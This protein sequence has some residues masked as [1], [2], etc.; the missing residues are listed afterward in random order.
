LADVFREPAR[1][2]I[3]HC[4]GG[5]LAK[6]LVIDDDDGMR[7]TVSRM[8]R[9]GGHEVIGAQDGDE[10]MRKF[11]T[12]PPDIVVTDILMPGKDGIET[13]LDLHRKCPSL[14]ILAMSGRQTGSIGYLNIARK[15]GAN[16]TLEKPFRAKDLLREIDKLLQR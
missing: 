11:Y 8:L 10:G 15:L 3:G 9:R 16:A 4:Q 12:N 2:L 6:I 1:G 7:R 13:I 5:S 14:P